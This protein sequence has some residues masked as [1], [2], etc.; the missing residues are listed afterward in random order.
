MEKKTTIIHWTIFSLNYNKLRHILNICCTRVHSSRIRTARSLGQGNVI[1]R[2]CHSVHRSGVCIQGVCIGG[3]GGRQTHRILRD[4]FNERA[5]RILRE[6]ILV[7][8]C[9]RC[10]LKSCLK[11]LC[12][13]SH[14]IR[15]STRDFSSGALNSMQGTRTR[16]P[17]ISYSIY[18]A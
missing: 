15:N 18:S 3:S 2:V 10:C 12:I 11:A 9:I 1:T 17:S 13:C 8:C 7:T 14:Y 6:C 5:V 4:M 16:R